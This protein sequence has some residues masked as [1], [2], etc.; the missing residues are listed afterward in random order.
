VAVVN[1]FVCN[2]ADTKTF[3]AVVGATAAQK[4]S[5]D[6]NAKPCYFYNAGTADMFV[7]WGPTASAAAATA[8]CLPCSPG[9][10]QILTID[11]NGGSAGIYASIYTVAATG[12]GYMCAGR[13]GV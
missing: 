4:I 7:N 1:A 6:G 5:A 2:P 11:S 3:V 12:N 13:D 9:S 10:T 8:N